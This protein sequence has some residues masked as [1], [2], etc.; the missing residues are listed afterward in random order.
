MPDRTKPP[1]IRDIQSLKLP[2]VEQRQLDNGLPAYVVNLGTQEVVKLEVIFHAGRPFERQPLAARATASQIREGSEKYSSAAVAE[3]LDFYGCTLSIPFQLDYSSFTLFSL[4]KH[5]GKALPLLKDLLQQP[6]FPEKEL[7]AFKLRNQRRLEIDLSKNDVVAYREATA[8]IF[9]ESHPYGYNSLPATYETLQREHLVEHHR[10]LY[11]KD[12]CVIFLSGR[13]DNELFEQVNAAFTE[14]LPAGQVAQADWA[15][16]PPKACQERIERPNTVQ[17][18]IR[19]GRPLFDR[20]HEDYMGMY[21]L[22]TLLGGYFSSRLMTNL[23]EEKGYTYNIYSSVDMMRYGGQ[24]LIGAEVGKDFVEDSL[25]QIYLEME[26]LQ[27]E[28]VEEDELQMVRNYLMGNFLTMLDGPFN[29]AEVV[30]TQV[31]EDLPMDYLEQLAVAVQ[32]ISPEQLQ[33]LAQR[34][35]SREKMAEVV[36]GP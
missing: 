13:V 32:E 29:V 19:I 17:S 28:R 12:N 7:Q 15:M 36:V 21:V 35:L 25:T 10:R 20:Q 14:A 5:F 11:N 2:D 30:R 1:K 16:P 18:A 34:Y 3:A 27:Q 33:I 23:R 6:A 4:N 8:C 31:L 22:N 24:L 9:G 26:R